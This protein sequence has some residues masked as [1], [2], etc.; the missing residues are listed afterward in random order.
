MVGADH[1]ERASR[2]QDALALPEPGAAESVIGREVG[3]A[4]PGLVDAVD[5]RLIWAIELARKLKVIGRVGEDQIDASR[6]KLLQFL[7]AVASE[8]HIAPGGT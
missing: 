6:R 2:L 4:V 7:Q 3:E 5:A 8:D 1:P